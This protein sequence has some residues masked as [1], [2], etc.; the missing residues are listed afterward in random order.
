MRQGQ[1]DLPYG[2]TQIAKLKSRSRPRGRSREAGY[3]AVRP[4]GKIDYGK[5]GFRCAA[6][7]KIENENDDED[8]DESPEFGIQ[9]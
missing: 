3:P 4:S 8:K 9:D 7:A 2:L 5:I 6:R 1:E